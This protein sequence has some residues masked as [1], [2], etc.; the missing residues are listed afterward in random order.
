MEKI[1][2]L[3]K[4]EVEEQIKIGNINKMPNDNLKSTWRIIFDNVFTL[5]NF[6][7]LIIAIAL[8]CVKAYTNV[9]FFFIIMINVM[10]GIIQEIHG[11]NLVKKLSILNEAKT[12]VIRNGKEKKINIDEIVLG[13]TIIL[14]QG[15]QIPSDS[16]IINGEV[17]VNE[18]LLTGESD[19]ILKNKNSK[20]LSGS[21][22]VSGKCYAIVEKVG[23]NNFANKIINSAKKQKPNNSELINSMKKVT[24]FTS[25]AIIPIGI[26]L[27]IQAYITRQVDLTQSVIATSAA[28]LGMLPKGLVLLITIS[29][30][31]G[32][33]K[34]AKKQVLVQDSY[35]I[36]SLAHID[37][38][39]LDKTGTITTGK[40]KVADVT[41]YKENILPVDF[42]KIMTAFVNGMGDNNATFKAL[43]KHF[44]GNTEYE[45][46]DNISFSS[47]RKW[48]SIS[49]KDIGSVV[50]G[51]PERLF[52]KSSE[53]MPQKIT[54]LQKHG[55]RVLAVAYT[56]QII[57]KPELPNLEIIA[58]IILEDP[59]RKNA[60]EMLGYF[61]EQ[62]IDVKIISGD[63][64]L[65]VSNISKEAGLENY[66]S[67]IDLSTIEKDEDIKNVVDKYSIFFFFLPHQK[68]I[69][70]KALQEKNHKVAMTGDGV[71]DVIAL[72][73]S[74]CSITLPDATESAKQVSKI[75]L[76]NSD[77][78]VLKGVLMEGRR[79]VNNIT[80]VARIFFIKTIYSVLLSIFCILTNMQ[81]PFIPIQITLIDLIIEAYTSFFISF[82]KN[83]RP[84]KGTFLKTALSNALPFALVIMLNIVFLTLAGNI[85]GIP[86]DSL[87]TIM[88]L[89]IGFVS[90]LAVQET[91]M[92]FDKKHLFLFSTTAIGF[93]VAVIL[94]KDLLHLANLTKENIILTV[95]LMCISYILIF[96]KR[97]YKFFNLLN[98]NIS[99]EEYSIH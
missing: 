19:L 23:E 32:V 81:F 46:I 45:K 8:I 36:E 24:K 60:K 63:N 85:I 3:S 51:A 69:I 96:I 78:S 87:S 28:L 82:E 15:D 6:Y 56:K 37:T 73:E 92:P 25:F 52:E 72:R 84:I 12:T 76:L 26:I 70:I 47:E 94:F 57:D 18:A 48:S 41:L 59:L 97:K 66:S 95:L 91:C 33:I 93:F 34:L 64:A 58:S 75:V 7:N 42:N 65:T 11:R 49:F 83:E 80:N 39:C 29:L 1:K 22:I 86:K 50:V 4:K 10:I 14:A 30:E 53:T 98:K 21:Y 99:S 68:S 54:E 67:Y 35:S 74:D 71:N 9:F 27:F 16:Y 2:G 55:K 61:K 20:L 5:F 77:F 43:Q 89:L 31:S 40:M 38:I 44:K 13:D 88:Y 79:V 17:E 62:C 90:I